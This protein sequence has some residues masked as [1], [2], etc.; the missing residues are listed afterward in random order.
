MTL[1][2]PVLKRCLGQMMHGIDVVGAAHGGVT[3]CYTSHWIMQ[4]SFE[5]P[6]V[7][8]SV[9]PKHDTWPLLE[10]SGRF[11]VSILA[12][13]QVAQ[14]QYFSYPGRRFRHVATEW[15]TTH[16]D[17]GLPVVPDSIAWL[18]CEVREITSPVVDH[19]LVLAEV[20]DVA[21]GR[22]RETPLVYSSRLGWRGAATK[23]RSA[24]D[25][26]RDTLLAR[27]EGQSPD[28]S[29]DEPPS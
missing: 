3:R 26:V 22:L 11:A 17:W 2:D 27:A 24:Q 20:T 25:A 13:D 28:G 19:R 10:A 9:S 5:E 21:E 16:E 7:M 6:V 14:A 12:A 8:A 1:I 4:V 23:V 15:V 18:R 29:P